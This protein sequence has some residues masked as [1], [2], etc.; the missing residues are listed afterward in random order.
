MAS[1]ICALSRKFVEFTVVSTLQDWQT[2]PARVADL[3][4]Q[5]YKTRYL[6]EKIAA[7][8]GDLAGSTVTWAPK[9]DTLRVYR[10][11]ASK[12]AYDGN[13]LILPH[14]DTPDINSELFLKVAAIPG[15][16]H[17]YD[18]GNKILGGPSPLSNAIV[19]GLMLGGAGYGAG[20]LA[21]NLFP[22][23]YIKRG[24]FRRTLGLMGLGAGA[25][26]GGVNAYT[27]AQLNDQ[28][29]LQALF[30]RNDNPAVPP[31]I[32]ALEEKA[33][34]FMPAN[35]YAPT[36][37]VP[38][39]NATTWQ[40]A[41]ANT[42]FN[43]PPSYAAAATGLMSGL[44]AQQRSPIIRPVDVI[45]GVASAGVGL[46][47]ANIAGRALSAMA[48]LT[49][50]GQKKLQDMGMWGGMLHAIVPSVFGARR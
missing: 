29:F 49:P 45:R 24:P 13:V 48:G 43:T 23:R 22:R 33:G 5:A 44:S 28:S 36:V 1:R 10:P 46:A 38:N 16:S 42:G 35:I 25:A 50:D 2:V 32:Q 6:Y 3:L 7:A 14:T 12:K 19:S 9:E 20:A 4:P 41:A 8:T 15:L 30:S 34:S 18:F 26:L 37:S 47:T 31:A 11:G 21:E 39:F 27:N 17:A 40:S